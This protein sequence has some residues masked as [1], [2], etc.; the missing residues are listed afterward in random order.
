MLLRDLQN[1]INKH[2]QQWQDIEVYVDTGD[3]RRPLAD[4]DYNEQDNTFVLIPEAKEQNK[5]CAKCGCR[6]ILGTKGKKYPCSCMENTVVK[7]Y[8]QKFHS[9]P[10]ATLNK[11]IY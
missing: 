6:P 9:K 11:N 1:K 5:P 2:W 4:T 3:G 8:S 10:F 7:E